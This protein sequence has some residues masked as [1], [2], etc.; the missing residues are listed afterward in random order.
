MH[1][2][3]GSW[4][5]TTRPGLCHRASRDGA[6]PDLRGVFLCRRADGRLFPSGQCAEFAADRSPCHAGAYL[7]FPTAWRTSATSFRRKI[8]AM[9]SGAG[10][11]LFLA[12]A[13]DSRTG[14][15][16]EPPRPVSPGKAVRAALTTMKHHGQPN[17]KYAL[18]AASPCPLHD[19]WRLPGAGG[20]ANRDN[21][22]ILDHIAR[23][24][25]SPFMSCMG[26]TTGCAISTRRK[27][28]WGPC[29]A[30]N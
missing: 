10:Q 23:R 18:T 26:V 14:A 2:F 25:I 12:A 27:L 29:D 3:G 20:G 30:G 24:G 6:D 21:N 7:D 9:S 8:A 22:Y 11:G 17:Q 28:W 16:G 13:D 15:L 4:G 5:S 19:Q 1:V